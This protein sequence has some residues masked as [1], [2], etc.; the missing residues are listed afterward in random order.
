MDEIYLWLSTMYNDLLCASGHSPENEI[1]KR[2]PFTLCHAHLYLTK[3][4]YDWDNK[5]AALSTLDISCEGGGSRSSLSAIAVYLLDTSDV[6]GCWIFLSAQ[7]PSNDPL[8]SD[9]MVDWNRADGNIQQ[10][11]TSKVA[12][13]ETVM[14]SNEDIDTPPQQDISN[15][16][17]AV[18]LSSQSS[19]DTVKYKRAWHRVK[20]IRFS[21]SFSGEC[22]DAQSRSFSIC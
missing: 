7:F 11:T 8:S 18:D 4:Y 21:I 22:P 10:P 13:T 15:L 9:D 6:V 16:F 1:E 20:G 2:I 19:Y 5:S 3:S 12:I 14:A 17:G